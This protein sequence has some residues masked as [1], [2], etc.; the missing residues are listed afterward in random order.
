MEV[1]GAGFGRTGT[2]SLQRALEQ[3]GFGPCHHMRVVNGDEE[4][5]AMW[6]RIAAGEPVPFR[7]ALAGFHSSCDWPS[8]HYWRQLCDTWPEAKV[9]LSVRPADE[10]YASMQR[11]ILPALAGS[12]DEDSVG[13]RLIWHEVFDGRLGDRDHAVAVYEAH[14]AAVVAALP[15][16]RLLVFRPTDG[17]GPLCAFLDVPVPDEVYPHRNR[18][19]EFRRGM[20]GR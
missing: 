10:W 20:E 17:W 4:Q 18:A 9:V 2:S 3:L 11:T 16:E 12:T 5:K 15:P 19:D 13:R 7:E 6:R 1:I 14:N 8:A